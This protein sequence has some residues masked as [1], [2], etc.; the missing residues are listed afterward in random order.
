MQKIEM[1]VPAVHP[2][3]TEYLE[4]PEQSIFFDIE[5]TG[6]HR[7]Y[8]HIYL[9]GALHCHEH[10]WTL[11]QWFAI[12]PVDESKMLQS[13]LSFIKDCKRLIHYNGDAF[14]LPYLRSRCEF[15]GIPENLGQGYESFDIYRRMRPF[16][17]L[18]GLERFTQKSVEQFMGITRTD[19]Y[20]GGELISVYKEYLQTADTN[21]QK[22]LLL[23]N[24]EDVINMASLLSLEAYRKLFEDKPTIKKMSFSE[25]TITITLSLTNAVPRPITCSSEWYSL[26]AQNNN[27]VIEVT[28]FDGTLKYYY[29]NPK[30]YYYLP[31]EDKAIH[32]SIGIYVDKEHR[33][34]ANA[35]TCYQKQSGLFAPQPSVITTPCFKKEHKDTTSFFLTE[36]LD[37]LSENQIQQY[38]SQIL[39]AIRT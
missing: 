37:A 19:P 30:D 20:D 2:L 25:D 16:Q 34:Q 5:T 23:H 9:I 33:K 27:A 32:K 26:S 31:L 39:Q 35:A 17:K 6:L 24:R 38:V 15:C 8:S 4:F 11:T 21:L 14:D 3:L 22:A 7:K 13:F 18:L 28:V 29:E 10:T 36:T 1:I 12:R